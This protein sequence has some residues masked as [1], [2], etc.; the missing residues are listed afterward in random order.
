MTN[1]SSGNSLEVLVLNVFVSKRKP[2]KEVMW[3]DS[4]TDTNF[5]S[6]IVV[7]HAIHE[8]KLD[9]SQVFAKSETSLKHL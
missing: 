1:G 8:R 9:V 7:D 6:R 3:F 5:R 2:A 4:E